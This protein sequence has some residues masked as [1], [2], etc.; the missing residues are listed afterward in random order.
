[1]A[2]SRSMTPAQ[3]RRWRFYAEALIEQAIEIPDAIDEDADLEDSG[4]G[5]PSLASP[6]GGDSQICWSTGSDDDREHSRQVAA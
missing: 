5:E 6:V 3:L 2:R 1:M 4:D